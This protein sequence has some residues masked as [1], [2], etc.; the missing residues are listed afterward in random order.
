MMS[1]RLA[2]SILLAAAAFSTVTIIA[3]A[4]DQGAPAPAGGGAAQGGGG[5]APGGG[6][7]AGGGTGGGAGTGR[8]P[9]NIPLPGQPGS[10]T[11][12]QQIPEFQR[13]IFISGKVMLED[14]TPPPDGVVIE[15]VCGGLPRPEGYTDSKGRFSIEVGRNQGMLSDASY[16]NE[17]DPFSS[18][19]GGGR[20]PGGSTMDRAQ[21]ERALMGCDITAKLPGY[22]SQAVSL[23][24][25]RSMDNPDI[26]TII[27]RRIANVE[28]LATSMTTLTAPKDARKAYGKGRDLMKKNK[29]A[30]AQKEF[31]KAIELHPNFASAW[32]E[33]GR[34]HL[35]GNKN[36]E[37]R[38]AFQKSLEADPKYVY[39]YLPLSQLAVNG[40][41]WEEAAELSGRLIRLNPIDFPHA[42]LINGVAN[43]NLKKYKEAEKSAQ[44]AVKLDTQH[45]MPKAHHLLGAVL[46]ENGELA[47]A[48]GQ[49]RDYLKFAP[50]ASDAE[51]V[52]KLIGQIESRL[53]VNSEAKVQPATAPQP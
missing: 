38:A 10:D 45:R 14:G 25:R 46:A 53:G 28:G 24:G 11:G 37:A 51:G 9:A 32:Y 16:G 49:L 18:S 29:L 40:Q 7:N 12:Q 33:L 4:Q 6:G 44:E 36:E 13:A 8:P 19:G 23:A 34:V 43:L 17:I 2:V 21:M 42:F 47:P 26:G 20:V 30:D 3:M 31:D 15:R 50:Q 22:R 48:A 1:A 52:R 41:K 35:A 39:P 27:M 5:V